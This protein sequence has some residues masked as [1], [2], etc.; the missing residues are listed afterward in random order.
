MLCPRRYYSHTVP[1]S[2]PTQCTSHCW[3]N[4]T[5]IRSPDCQGF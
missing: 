5:L 3:R 4:M 2:K 1:Q